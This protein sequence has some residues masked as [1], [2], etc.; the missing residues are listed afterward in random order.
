[1]STEDNKALVHRAFEVLN[2]K[3]LSVLDELIDP[4]FVYHFAAYPPVQGIKGLQQVFS[5]YLTAFPDLQMTIEDLIG[6]GDKVAARVTGRGTQRGELMGIP[7][8]GKQVTVTAL[9]IF[10]IANGKLVEQWQN[11]DDLGLMQ[12]LGV[13]P[14]QA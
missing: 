13:V 2:K 5:T 4:N 1:M 11:S 9:H 6:E 14:V 3:N 10:R 8:T 12:Q 7:P